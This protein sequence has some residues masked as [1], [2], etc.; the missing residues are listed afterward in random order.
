MSLRYPRLA[1]STCCLRAWRTSI[2][3]HGD[4]GHYNSRRS[5]SSRL[6]SLN[7]D[8]DEFTEDIVVGVLSTGEV[9]KDLC[10]ILC[11][12]TRGQTGTSGYFYLR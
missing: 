9:K 5:F 12:T 1:V 6:I 7:Y 4:C 3:M 11:S 2:R 8:R 10:S